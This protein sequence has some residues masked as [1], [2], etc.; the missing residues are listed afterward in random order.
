[1]GA[2]KRWRCTRCGQTLGVLSGDRLHIRL[3]RGHHITCA[4]PV[5]CQ[6]PNR[7]CRELN[8]ITKADR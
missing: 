7:Y 8:E 2:E 1:M 4:L 5:T 3:T 6:C